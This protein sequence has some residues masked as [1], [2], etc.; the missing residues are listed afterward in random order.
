MLTPGNV[1][2]GRT[3]AYN[4]EGHKRRATTTDA[5]RA[6]RI[7]RIGLTKPPEGGDEQDVAAGRSCRRPETVPKDQHPAGDN[8]R[9]IARS[10]GEAQWPDRLLGSA[11][12]P[13][14][15]R[16]YDNREH[17]VVHDDLHQHTI[18]DDHGTV[19]RAW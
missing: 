12:K 6:R 2:R 19:A 7:R 17:T 13:G 9:V 15:A 5:T 4:G 1:V 14:R 10:H 3:L 16:A 8:E 18:T 11:S